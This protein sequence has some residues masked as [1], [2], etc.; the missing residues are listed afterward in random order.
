MDVEGFVVIGVVGN[1]GR[2]HVLLNVSELS[3]SLYMTT[4][5]GVHDLCLLL[6]VELPLVVL[7]HLLLLLRQFGN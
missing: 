1:I 2:V 4:W 6:F 7:S 5:I 3:H